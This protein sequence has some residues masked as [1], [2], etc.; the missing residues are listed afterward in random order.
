MSEDKRILEEVEELDSYAKHSDYW[1]KY[2]EV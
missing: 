2:V 1:D